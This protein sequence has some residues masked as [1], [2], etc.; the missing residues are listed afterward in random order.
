[1]ALANTRIAN[2]I[3]I[4]CIEAPLG[5]SVTLITRMSFRSIPRAAPSPSIPLER[6]FISIFDNLSIDNANIPNAAA[7]IT[8]EP[9]LIL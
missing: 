5:I 3:P 6:S 8:K 7:I 9:I 2:A 4:N 1:M